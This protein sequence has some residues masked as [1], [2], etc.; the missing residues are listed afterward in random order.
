MENIQYG[1]FI[2][3]HGYHNEFKNKQ[4]VLTSHG[5]TNPDV[6]LEQLP[7]DITSDKAQGVSALRNYRDYIFQVWPKLDFQATKVYNKSVK[8][9][10]LLEKEIKNKEDDA[11]M[12]QHISKQRQ[13]LE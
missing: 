7:L 5:H 13:Y 8:E 11:Q 9:I 1:D 10:T 4:G 6:N 12:A 3:I 2:L